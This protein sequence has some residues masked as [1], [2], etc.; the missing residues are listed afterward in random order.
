MHLLGFTIM[1]RKDD[2]TITEEVSDEPPEGCRLDLEDFYCSFEI[3]TEEEIAALSSPF[4]NTSMTS[5]TSS[6]SISSQMS[7]SS[8]LGST[9]TGGPPTVI[10]AHQRQSFEDSEEVV[11][12]ELTAAI[13]KA[14]EELLTENEFTAS[15]RIWFHYQIKGH[16]NPEDD[17][18][19]TKRVTTEESSVKWTGWFLNLRQLPEKIRQQAADKKRF[20]INAIPQETR[21]QLKHLYVY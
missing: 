11:E 16:W 3:I 20:N 5:S 15:G 9:G 10:K 6:S 17:D 19:G 8:S 7:S 14:A 1:G 2:T 12:N 13:R 4:S 21:D 18:N